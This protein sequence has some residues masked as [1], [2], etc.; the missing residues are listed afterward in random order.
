MFNTIIKN[1]SEIP[2]KGYIFFLNI[3]L[4]SLNQFCWKTSAADVIQQLSSS[5]LVRMIHTRDGSRI[6]ILCIKHGSAKV[7]L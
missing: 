5:L 7:C 1:Q 6:G 2:F 4:F 3:S